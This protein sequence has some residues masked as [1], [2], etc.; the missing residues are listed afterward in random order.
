MQ[1]DPGE[2]KTRD[3][4]ERD[5]IL[6]AQYF[7]ACLFLGR[8]KYK[9]RRAESLAEAEEIAHQMAAETGKTIMIYAV[10]G[11]FTAHVENI[12][13]KVLYAD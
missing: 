11:G 7:T 13:P 8:A 4:F 12:K 6:N 1:L 10:C 2:Y 5:I 9:T 3:S